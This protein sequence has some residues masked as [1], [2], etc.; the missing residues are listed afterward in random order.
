MNILKA[1]LSSKDKLKLDKLNTVI[2]YA[3]VDEQQLLLISSDTKNLN[4]S[5]ETYF[6]N[7]LENSIKIEDIKDG[8]FKSI[9]AK[10]DKYKNKYILINLFDIDDYT[11]IMEEFQ[12]KRDYIPQEKLKF[13]FLFNQKQYESFKTKAYDFFSFNN[14]FHHFIDNTYTFVNDIDLSEL[15]DMIKEYEKIKDTNISK[16][17]RMKYL[18]DIAQKAKDFSQ[19]KKSLKYLDKT[20]NLAN[21]LKDN[22]MTSV[23]NHNKSDVYLNLG[24][25]DQSLMYVKK[26][27][28]AFE[29]LKYQKGIASSHSLMGLIYR[30]LGNLDLALNNFKSTLKISLEEKLHELEGIAKSNIGLIYLDQGEY[31]LSL[32]YENEALTVHKE[33]NDILGVLRIKGN[34][35]LLHQY[36]GNLSLALKY[37]NEA[38]SLAKENK[39]IIHIA[40][41]LRNIG[42]IY[43]DKNDLNMALKHQNE[44]LEIFK[45]IGYIKGVC[46]TLNDISN[47][48]EKLKNFDLVE[49]YR[50][51]ALTIAKSLG[52]NA[53]I[54]KIKQNKINNKE[55]G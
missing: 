32:Q 34:L 6:L 35:G 31:D 26:S 25:L 41:A 21:K 42:N 20:L 11:N 7:S 53:I 12:F 8:L 27:L 30:D 9:L 22:F 2:S 13:I 48:Y 14:F 18:Y 17:N 47:V 37:Q 36:K 24:N 46:E 1:S 39:R 16:Q 45:E 15:D 50:E 43:K 52:F 29:K 28:K 55:E 10:V 19:Y 33:I 54:T 49:K 23:V 3:E 38:L 44:A 40:I 4:Q 51:E 5:F